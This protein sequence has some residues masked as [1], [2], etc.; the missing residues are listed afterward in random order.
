MARAL[1]GIGN[2]VGVCDGWQ[3]GERRYKGTDAVDEERLA[4][5]RVRVLRFDLD[6]PQ[7][8]AWPARSYGGILDQLRQARG[9]AT[10]LGFEMQAY[11]TGGRGVDLCLPLPSE[12]TI[13]AASW[14][15]TA[16]SLLLKDATDGPLVYD[17]NALQA[18]IRLPGQR[19]LRSGRLGLWI[20]LD[21][22]PRATQ[23]LVLSATAKDIVFNWS[24]KRAGK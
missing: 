22:R 21:G 14:I 2:A 19:H 9:L 6:L 15:A 1:L 24:L 7:G 10:D 11:T 17:T 5:A 16:F 12:T 18:P 20:D 4:G 8:E 13:R 3:R 23:Q